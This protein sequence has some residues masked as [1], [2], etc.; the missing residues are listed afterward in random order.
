MFLEETL[1]DQ[2]RNLGFDLFLVHRSMSTNCNRRRHAC[3]FALEFLAVEGP[4][5]KLAEQKPQTYQE[6]MGR[7]LGRAGFKPYL[8]ARAN[9]GPTLSKGYKIVH[10]TDRK[11][12]R[13]EIQSFD[14]VLTAKPTEAPTS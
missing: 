11:S 10:M 5:L 13:M 7:E 6:S 9:L 14:V 1:A 2:V 8:A 4:V 12:Y 3:G